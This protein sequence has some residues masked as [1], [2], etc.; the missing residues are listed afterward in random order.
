[1]YVRFV[2]V[3]RRERP[4]EARELGEP[5]RL[6]V[7]RLVLAQ[8][9]LERGLRAGVPVRRH[10]IDATSR[11]GREEGVEP[12]ERVRLVAAAAAVVERG[13]DD[14]ELV[15]VG[16]GLNLGP[17][18]GAC[19]GVRFD[20]A[21]KLGSLNVRRYFAPAG[22]WVASVVVSKVPPQIIGTNST[23]VEV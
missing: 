18:R 9:P 5:E 14:R 12:R 8:V 23:P 15:R 19:A 13:G 11:A 3:R 1:M 10:V 4:V 20:W 21:P 17:E 7:L 6:V 2:R 16:E 22:T